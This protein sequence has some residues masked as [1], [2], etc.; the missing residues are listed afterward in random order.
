MLAGAL[1][2]E[3]HPEGVRT[4]RELLGRERLLRRDAEEVVHVVELVVHEEQRV[5]AEA[6]PVREQDSF[7]ALVEDGVGDDL[8]GPAAD[9]DRHALGDG[10]RTGVVHV[11][12]ARRLGLRA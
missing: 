5:P 9:V 3:L 4:R 10:G 6:G 2:E 12:I 7:G 8:V 11:A 1:A